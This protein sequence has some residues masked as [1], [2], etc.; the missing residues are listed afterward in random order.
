M[1]VWS[2]LEP[3]R[4]L[5]VTTCR[6]NK[7]KNRLGER[8]PAHLFGPRSQFLTLGSWKPYTS[9]RRK[10]EFIYCVNDAFAKLRFEVRCVSWV[11]W[12]V[13]LFAFVL[14]ASTAGFLAIYLLRFLYMCLQPSRGAGIQSR[15]LSRGY[16]GSTGGLLGKPH[17]DVSW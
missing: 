15:L 7:G 5:S 17:A 12:I 11:C 3:C 4:C 13:T 14:S 6:E 16:Y 9:E 1:S 2:F 8:V 10:R